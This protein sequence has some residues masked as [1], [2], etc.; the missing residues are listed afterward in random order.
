[1]GLNMILI[2]AVG[3]G[4]LVLYVAYK[5]K[6]AS[7]EIDRL[8]KSNEQLVR[9]KAVTETQVK[10]FEA[11]KYNEENSRNLDRTALIERMQKSG[12]LRD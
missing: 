7:C 2:G 6:R 3:V 10:H 12:D 1:M 8:L 4:L 11:R 5:L 9:E